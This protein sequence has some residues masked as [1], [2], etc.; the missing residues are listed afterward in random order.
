MYS[1]KPMELFVKIPDNQYSVVNIVGI[2]L[3]ISML[4][5]YAGFFYTGFFELSYVQYF[6]V[7]LPNVFLEGSGDNITVPT[8]LSIGFMLA[9]LIDLSFEELTAKN[10]SI[11]CLKRNRHLVYMLTSIS[12]ILCGIVSIRVFGLTFSNAQYF[13]DGVLAVIVSYVDLANRRVKG[14]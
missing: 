4:I 8:V 10:F 9:L 5:S 3:A 13:L 12:I 7:K 2:Y 1:T 11:H 14:N 6:S